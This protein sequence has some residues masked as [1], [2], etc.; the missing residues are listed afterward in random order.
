MSTMAATMELGY[1]ALGETG[2][3]AG[4]AATGDA[5]GAGLPPSM[6]ERMTLILDRFPDRHARLSLEQVSRS[7]GLPRST[8]HRI[9]EQLVR[10]E[11]LAHTPEGY[12]LGRRALGLGGPHDHESLRAAASPHL[13]ELLMRTGAVVHLGVLDGARVRYL[14][15]LGGRFASRVPSRVGGAAPAHCTGLGR[16]MLAWLAPEEVDTVLDGPLGV[17][18]AATIGDLDALHLELGRIRG[19]GGLAVERGECVRGLGCVAAAIRVGTGSA[20]VLGAVSVVAELDRG[21]DR[22]GP[23]V[24]A[25][26]RRIS[27][28]LRAEARVGA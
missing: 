6:V 20:G 2:Q 17:R 27:L 26:A 1:E 23:L 3:Q 24:V 5:R 28:D 11:W 8:A 9:L 18:T 13:H 12:A 14:D 16:A 7:T 15:K 22:V 25:A 4:G 10:L 21:L 19:R